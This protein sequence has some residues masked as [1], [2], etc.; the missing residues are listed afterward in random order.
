MI[1][2]G[3]TCQSSRHLE[4]IYYINH[5]HMEEVK[6]TYGEHAFDKAGSQ[7]TGQAFL[8]GCFGKLFIVLCGS[9]FR[10]KPKCCFGSIQGH[11]N[12]DLDS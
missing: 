10:L 5:L 6:A 3:T 9:G 7:H 11:A 4:I 8:E 2:I 12:P 1:M